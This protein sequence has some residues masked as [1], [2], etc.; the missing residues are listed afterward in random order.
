MQYPDLSRFLS[1]GLSRLAP[2]PVGVL[3]MEDFTET[4]ST[5]RHH[6]GLGLANL[7]VCGPEN[8]SIS[9][10]LADHVHHV[11]CDTTADGALGAIINPLIAALA[12]RWMFYG[13][14]AEYLFY[15]FCESR[16][17]GEVTAFAS[18]ERRES[19]LTYVIDLYADD[20]AGSPDGV[21]LKGAHLDRAGYYAHS[22]HRDG[23]VM[24]RQLDMFGGLRWRFEEHVPWERRK[25]DRI[26]LFRAK[27]GLELREDHTFTEE[28]YNTYSCPWHHNLTA[29]ICS[30]RVAKALKRNPG[31]TFDI[32]TFRWHNSTR[33]EWHSRQLLDLGLME[34]GQWF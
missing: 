26:G 22:R 17:V 31:S 30:F 27:K 5:I 2:G 29:A 3:L 7:L 34:P 23:Q 28:E 11:I 6:R 16:S 4:N 33:F 10:E 1:K 32:P 15:P 20:L 18:E 13:Y 19:I 8:L 14:N 21:S 24:E 9:R 25:I 12:G